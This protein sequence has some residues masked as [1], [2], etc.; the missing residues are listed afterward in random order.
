MLFDVGLDAGTR[1]HKAEEPLHFIGHELEI[2]R[3]GEGQEL[4]KKSEDIG[5]PDP[6]MRTAAGS[7]PERIAPAQ[8]GAAQLVK[9]RLGDAELERGAR[10]IK[11]VSVELSQDTPDKLR[12]QAVDELVFSSVQNAARPAN[13]WR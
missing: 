2:G 7:G 13:P 4:R 11:E 8:P 5:Q 3:V 9:P 10:R 12:R 6:A 1:P